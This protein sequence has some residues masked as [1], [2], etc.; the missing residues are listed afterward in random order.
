MPE[1][2]QNYKKKIIYYNNMKFVQRKK[3]KNVQ[4]NVKMIFDL[5][6]NIF[7]E[8]EILSNNISSKIYYYFEN[9]HYSLG[10]QSIINYLGRLNLLNFNLIKKI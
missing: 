5:I 10:T 9:W 1:I 7:Y 8:Y 2:F 4:K 6:L 3:F